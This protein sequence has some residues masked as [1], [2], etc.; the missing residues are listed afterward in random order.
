MVPGEEEGVGMVDP[1]PANKSIAMRLNA[2]VVVMRCLFIE[3]ASPSGVHNFCLESKRNGE[4]PG[5]PGQS[6]TFRSWAER[7]IQVQVAA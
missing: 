4:V 6:G 1:H 3:R 7:G 2:K 5:L